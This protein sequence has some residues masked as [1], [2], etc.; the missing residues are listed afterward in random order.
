VRRLK[1]LA[2]IG[3]VLYVLAHVQVHVPVAG[4]VPALALAACPVAGVL[5]V[6][7]AGITRAIRG[8]S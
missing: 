8:A 6:A 4:P 5:A 3:L 7:A 2:L 1:V